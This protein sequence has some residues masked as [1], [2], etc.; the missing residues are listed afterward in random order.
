MDIIILTLLTGALA[1]AVWRVVTKP[2]Q[3]AE[4]NPAPE[5]PPAPVKLPSDKEILK[6]KKLDIEALG[7]EWGVELDRR[8]TKANMVKDLRK[9]VKKK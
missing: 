9:N 4:D 8:M 7:R 1:Y 2:T 3:E 6:L 5:V